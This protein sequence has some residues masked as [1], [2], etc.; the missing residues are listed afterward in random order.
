M[1]RSHSQRLCARVRASLMVCCENGGGLGPSWAIGSP[2][3]G[4]LT[5]V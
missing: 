1:R 4:L 5:V 2:G 3:P